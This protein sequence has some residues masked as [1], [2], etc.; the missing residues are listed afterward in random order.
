MS[1]HKEVAN[2]NE[3]LTEY[4][5]GEYKIPPEWTA[6]YSDEKA[7]KSLPGI[8]NKIKESADSVS[9]EKVDVSYT[10]TEAGYIVNGEGFEFALEKD[11]LLKV[12]QITYDMLTPILP[13]GSVVVLD[14]S[15][16][17]ELN[18]EDG[19]GDEEE[20]RVVIQTRFVFKNDVPVYFP[21]GGVIYPFGNLLTNSQIYF[22]PNLIKDIIHMGYTD[23]A[24]GEAITR[25]KRELI[26]ERGF[27]SMGFAA[28]ED[29]R[30]FS[31][32][33]KGE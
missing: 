13:L 8:F 31:E 25:T 11:A 16:M 17:A 9:N 18:Q 15:L 2:M 6:V 22:T 20:L 10:L 1:G 33:M 28:D 30:T 32:F 4:L 24:D 14:K 12:I 3:L 27:M 7:S 21:Y 29:K 23:E 19:D 26:I 5:S